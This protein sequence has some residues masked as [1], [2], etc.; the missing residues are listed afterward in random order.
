MV[1]L[2]EVEKVVALEEVVTEE[3]WAE[4]GMEGE[5]LVEF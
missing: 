4:E 2:E 1:A 3:G 5:T